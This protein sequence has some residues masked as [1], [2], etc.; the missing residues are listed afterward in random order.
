M[1]LHADR[2]SGVAPPLARS[3]SVTRPVCT[4]FTS[5]VFAGSICH[6]LASY[7][8]TQVLPTLTESGGHRSVV[9][10]AGNAAAIHRTAV[11]HDLTSIHVSVSLRF[12]ARDSTRDCRLRMHAGRILSGDAARY[13]PSQGGGGSA[14]HGERAGA[15]ALRAFCTPSGSGGSSYRPRTIAASSASRAR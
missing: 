13:A 3:A 10:W 12:F 7:V 14:N 9:A 2:L 1:A 6:R 4:F 5:A 8:S 15:A 11:T